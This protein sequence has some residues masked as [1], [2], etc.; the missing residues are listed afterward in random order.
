MLL[1]R[2]PVGTIGLCD[3]MNLQGSANTIQAK[4]AVAGQTVAQVYCRAECLASAAPLASQTI[5]IIY[6]VAGCSASAAAEAQVTLLRG[7]VMSTSG[8]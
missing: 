2:S 4:K 1:W 8:R 3:L 6:W 7:S 5:T